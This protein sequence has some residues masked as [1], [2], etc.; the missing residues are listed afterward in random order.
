MRASV[1]DA[2]RGEGLAARGVEVTALDLTAGADAWTATLAGAEGMILSANAVTP[3]AGDR[4]DAV[5]DGAE[6]L[7]EAAVAAGVHRIVL[8]SIPVTAVDEAVPFAARRRRLEARVTGTAPESRVVRMPP[9][10][11]CWLALVG[12]SLPLRGE[13]YATIGRPSPFLRRFRGLTGSV[14]EDRGLM[15]VPGSPA[16]RHAFLSVRDAARICVEAAVR[17]GGGS[18][19]IDAAGPEVLSWRQVAG[20]FERVLGRRVRIMSTPAAVYGVLARVMGP[21]ADVPSRTMAL[22]RYL[23]MGETPW[24]SA[25]GGLVDPASLTTVESFLRAKA[26]LPTQLPRVL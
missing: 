23:A 13:P 8:P 26:A 6:R 15:L 4:P 11:E 10:M 21:V 1:R 17:P 7:V 18:Q 12:S 25:G 3:R 5:E 14:V 20:I 19:T 24:T 22:N 9:F 16:A 2:A